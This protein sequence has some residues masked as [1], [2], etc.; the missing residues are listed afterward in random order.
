MT[1]LYLLSLG[2][3]PYCQLCQDGLLTTVQP[4]YSAGLCWVVAVAS[5]TALVRAAHWQRMSATHWLSLGAIV[6]ANCTG[7]V[8]LPGVLMQAL[9]VSS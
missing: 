7:T 4:C 8:Y 2:P 9:H 1:V 3:L 6:Q 5:H